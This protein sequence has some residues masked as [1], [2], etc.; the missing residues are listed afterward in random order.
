MSD[1]DNLNFDDNQPNKEQIDGKRKLGKP[2]NLGQRLLTAVFLAVLYVG[3]I[4]LTIYVDKRFFYGL[5]LVLTLTSAYEFSKAIGL[6][7]AKP[8]DFFV[9]A[10]VLVGMLLFFLFSEYMEKRGGITAAFGTVV[11][12]FIICI[13]YVMIN[14]K[15]D[16]NNALSTLFVMIYPET[17]MMYMLALAYLGDNMNVAIIMAFG[18]TTLTDTMAYFVGSVFGGKKL[19]PHISPN[20]TISGSIGG[21]F[22]GV[23]AGVVVWAFARYGVFGCV[24]I[25]SSLVP[26]LLNFMFLGLITAISCQIGDLISSYIKRQCGIKDFGNVLRGHG[27]FMDRV[28]GLIVASVFIYAYFIVYGLVVAL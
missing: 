7:Y 1:Q 13:A 12:M 18:A 26:D 28:D 22:G 5:A 8:I 14:Q 2:K 16:M 27:G 11:V 10:N 24:P 3:F 6:K 17:I 25:A 21:L 20:K 9:Y 15:H 4:V 23:A 19:C